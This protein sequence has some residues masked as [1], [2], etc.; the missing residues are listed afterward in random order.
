VDIVSTGGAC[1][2][3]LFYG[4][5]GTWAD[6]GLPLHLLAWGSAFATALI[7]LSLVRFGVRGHQR[8]AT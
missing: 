2:Y 5:V 3:L 4:L 8:Q 7:T 6:W 1:V